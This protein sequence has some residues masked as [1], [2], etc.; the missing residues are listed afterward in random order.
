[1][2]GTVL[3]GLSFV[4]AGHV[5][6]YAVDVPKSYDA[7][8]PVGLLLDPG[9]GSGAKSDAKDKARFLAMFRRH[10]DEAGL[11]DWLVVRTE[12]LE[13]VGADGL[14]AAVARR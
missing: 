8:K 4:H 10:A 14:F 13:Q 12:I 9:H 11:S 3:S 2:F 6:R 1:V 5:F 7:T